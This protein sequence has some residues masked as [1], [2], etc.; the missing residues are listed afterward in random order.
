MLANSICHSPKIRNRP[1]M[2][3]ANTG[4]MVNTAKVIFPALE[5]IPNNG[6]RKD[7]R[8]RCPHSLNRTRQQEEEPVEGSA[9]EEVR[10]GDVVWF[11]PAEKHWHRA[12]ATTA[13]SHIAVAEAFDGKTV[14]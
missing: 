9:K 13:M 3:G 8:S 4:T 14:D 2:A 7:A 5:T 1:P 11:P 10:P 12:T 6:Y